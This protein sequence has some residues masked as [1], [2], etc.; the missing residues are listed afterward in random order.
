M[1]SAGDGGFKLT[2]LPDFAIPPTHA[3]SLNVRDQTH[4]SGSSEKAGFG[5]FFSSFASAEA[6]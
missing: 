2:Q 1:L 3:T 5:S 6:G 4:Q